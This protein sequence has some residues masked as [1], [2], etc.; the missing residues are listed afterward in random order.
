[1]TD[2]NISSLN[3]G[4]DTITVDGTISYSKIYTGGGNDSITVDG[5]ITY[6]KIYTGGGNDSVSF[7]GLNGSREENSILNTGDGDD[8]IRIGA[9]GLGREGT[10]VDAGTGNN[11]V[12]KTSQEGYLSVPITGEHITLEMPGGTRTEHDGEYISRS[13]AITAMINSIIAGSHSNSSTAGGPTEQA[14]QS[15]SKPKPTT[16]EY[17]ADIENFRMRLLGYYSRERVGERMNDTLM[18]LLWGDATQKT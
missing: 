5:N 11:T 16:E 2:S 13:A 1:M 18:G 6:S 10:S 7:E 4:D 9:R 15:A 3:S 17:L 12:I 8:V 14:R